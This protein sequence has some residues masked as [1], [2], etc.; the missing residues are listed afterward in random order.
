MLCVLMMMI[1]VD[2]G[3]GF[4]LNTKHV[5][6][7]KATSVLEPPDSSLI[8][9]ET[10]KK[11]IDTP[12]TLCSN[13]SADELNCTFDWNCTFSQPN[14]TVVCSVKNSSYPCLGDR[15]FFKNHSCFFCYQ[16]PHPDIECLE[17]MD[18]VSGTTTYKTW[19]HAKRDVL[20]MGSRLF[21]ANRMCMFTTGKV[22]F[23]AVVLSMILGTLGIDRC[24]LGDVGWGFLK[25]FSCGGFCVWAIV[26]VF[27]IVTF[28]LGP[29]D[30]SFWVW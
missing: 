10:K 1:I 11:T 26:D 17:F 16:L 8:F 3:F 18:C 2:C 14:I 12:T 9:Y 24:Y 19:C 23:L 27:L 7:L 21:E 28:S 4:V 29:Q 22:W 5:E 6:L 30:G 13:I 25:C 20:C 15:V